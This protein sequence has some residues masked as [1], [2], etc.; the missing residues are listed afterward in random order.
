MSL[1]NT[2]NASR[3][4]IGIYGKRNSGKSSL[5]NAITGQNTAI[6][7]D[8]AGTTADPVYKPMEIH[9]FGPCVFIDTAG[10]DDELEIGRLRV[11]K[12]SETLD[13]A[14]VALVLFNGSDFTYEKK[15]LEKLKTKKTPYI[16]IVSKAD[17]PE[18]TQL[19]GLIETEFGKK[20]IEVS[21]KNKTG[22]E[23]IKEEILRSIPS[24]FEI[25]SI[26]ANFVRKDDVV[27]LVMP[28][29]SGAPKGRLILP[30]VQT[31]RDLLDNKCVVVSV[32]TEE[33]DQA[34]SALK[35]PPKLIIVDSQVFSQISAKKPPESLLTSFSILYAAYKGDMKT[36]IKGADAIDRL[37]ENDTVLIAEACTH[38]P[39]EEDIGR[40]K[41]PA[42]LRKKVG[43]GLKIEITRGVDF[44]ENSEVL[45]RYALII[46]CGGCMFNR[47]YIMSRIIKAGNTPITNYGIALAKLNGI[48]DSVMLP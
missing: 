15:W 32:V 26:T 25:P 45:K 38:A 13:R 21:A 18:M 9:P 1:L 31:T 4:H 28:Q 23:G 7:S 44:P 12:T 8:V 11:E 19:S 43:Q 48:L 29:D 2:P 35:K 46:H 27:M 5:I 34:V 14:D 6:V 41:L 30:Q 17:L 39:M 16:L 24:D 47:K 22:I 36:L 3:L 42:L 10:F 33:F 40:V 37:T 20:P